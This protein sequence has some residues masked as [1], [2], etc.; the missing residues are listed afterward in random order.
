[1]PESSFVFYVNVEPAFSLSRMNINGRRL[2]IGC[3]GEHLDA[4]R[5]SNGASEKST[6]LGYSYLYWYVT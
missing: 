2:K 3:F 5:E 4:R 6:E 1:M